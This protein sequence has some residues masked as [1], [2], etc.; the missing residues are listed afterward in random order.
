MP[1]PA[2]S[3]PVVATEDATID[4][5]G[6][7][8]EDGVAMATSFLDRSLNEGREVVFLLHGLGTGALRDALRKELASSPY[9]ARSRG[10]VAGEG[11]DAVTVVWLA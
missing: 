6:L 5:R 7:R 11:G 3:A 9:V 1:R 4:L 8:V 10:G 2:V